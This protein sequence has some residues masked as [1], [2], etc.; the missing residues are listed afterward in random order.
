MTTQTVSWPTFSAS[1]LLPGET[2]I[3]VFLPL[4]DQV[5]YLG[6]NLD[7]ICIRTSCIDFF[8]HRSLVRPSLIRLIFSVIIPFVVTVTVSSSSPTDAGV[9]TPTT[10]STASSI[11][12]AA[13]SS[14]GLSGG[15]IGGIVGGTIGGVIVLAA[16]I[17]FVYIK[18]LKYGYLLRREANRGGTAEFGQPSNLETVKDTESPQDTER[19]R[20]LGGGGGI[21]INYNIDGS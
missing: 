17:A 3:N 5:E 7:E 4:W 16:I 12:A 1:R 10:T 9:I 2:L 11:S 14:S 21:P 6:T 15:T 13:G 20:H 18:S 8:R 19:G